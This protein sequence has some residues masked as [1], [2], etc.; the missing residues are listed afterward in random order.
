MK[1]LDE[2]HIVQG[3]VHTNIN[4]GGAE[5][6][7]VSLKNYSHC[8]IVLD[9]GNMTAGGNGDVV[10]RAADDV[11]H[12][13]SVALNNFTMRKSP[14]SASDDGFAEEVMIADS[15]I[16]LVAGGE[17]V[18]D[19]D[20]NSLVVIDVDAVQ[21]RAAGS[22][23]EYDCLYVTFSDPGQATPVGCKFIL[24]GPRHAAETMPSAIID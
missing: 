18:P 15:K 16:D 2:L 22:D 23:Y 21:V 6:D 9:F 8:A 12:T 10:I 14:A 5:S 3:W 4:G 24:S 13:H 17:I 1:L 7:V 19:T 11:A 20:D